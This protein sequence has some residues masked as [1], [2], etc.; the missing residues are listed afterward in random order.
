MSM[1]TD[2]PVQEGCVHE[3]VDVP[4]QEGEHVCAH[5]CVA[6]GGWVGDEC[7]CSLEGGN[8]LAEGGGKWAP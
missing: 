6:H 4:V 8:G 7:E 2:V 3:Y 5:G 1:W